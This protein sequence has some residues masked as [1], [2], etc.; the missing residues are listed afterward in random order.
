VITFGNIPTGGIDSGLLAL[1]P[2]L[3]VLAVAEFIRRRRNPEA[4]LVSADDA[5]EAIAAR[6]AVGAGA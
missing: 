6:P 4:V 2:N 3:A 1:A 5:D